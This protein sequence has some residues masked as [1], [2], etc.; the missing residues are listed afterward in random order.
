MAALIA[1]P[2]LPKLKVDAPK[3]GCNIM[4]GTNGK[5][6]IKGEGW[7]NGLYSEVGPGVYQF[8]CV[9][10]TPDDS[11]TSKQ[12]GDKIEITWTKKIPRHGVNSREYVDRHI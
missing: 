10:M 12:V 2:F 3:V 4:L 5:V 7:R 1:A 9:Q 6:W 8:E 11:L